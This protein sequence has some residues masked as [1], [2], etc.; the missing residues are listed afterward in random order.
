MPPKF[1]HHESL[2][3]GQYF[4]VKDFFCTLWIGIVFEKYLSRKDVTKLT[5]RI[6]NYG[7]SWMD[8]GASV[9]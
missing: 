4:N 1:T 7:S 3:A 9:Y 8:T 5:G 2:L 6:A